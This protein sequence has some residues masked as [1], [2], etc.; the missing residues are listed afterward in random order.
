MLPNDDQRIDSP[1]WWLEY[2]RVGPDS[3]VSPSMA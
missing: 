3:T 2:T 1:D